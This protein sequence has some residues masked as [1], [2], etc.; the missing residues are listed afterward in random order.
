VPYKVVWDPEAERELRGLSVGNRNLAKASVD[1]LKADPFN[2]TTRE[3]EGYPD[4]RK[5]K[6]AGNL[7]IIFLVEGEWITIEHVG[8]SPRVYRHYP[9]PDSP[10]YSN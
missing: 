1:A 7:R 3:V 9:R 6:F 2:H 5:A 10:D 8:P 4:T